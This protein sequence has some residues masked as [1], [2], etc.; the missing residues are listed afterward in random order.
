MGGGGSIQN[1][2]NAL[3]QNKSMLRSR[4]HFKTM[5]NDGSYAPKRKLKR[6]TFSKKQ[7][8]QTIN[9]HRSLRRR[10]LLKRLV[11][12]TISLFLFWVCFIY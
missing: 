7:T 3:K 2:V 1:M 10:L 5:R 9:K 6:G 11:A 4:N 8:L 12:L